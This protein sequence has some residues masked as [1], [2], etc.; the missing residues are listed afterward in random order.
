MGADVA[1]TVGDTGHRRI[2][3]PDGQLSGALAGDAQLIDEPLLDILRIDGGDLAD[4]A[5]GDHLAGHLHHGVAGIGIGDAENQVFLLGQGH[6]LLRLLHS[7]AQRLFA[8]HMDPVLQEA[9]GHGVVGVVRGGDADEID[10]VG[11]LALRLGHGLIAGVHAAHVQGVGLAGLTVLL[12][13]GGEAARHQLCAGVK[14]DGFAMHL[15]DKGVH[16][17]T[18]HAVTDLNTHIVLLVAFQLAIASSNFTSDFL[19]STF[20]TKAAASVAPSI[21]SIPLSSHSTDRGPS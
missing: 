3:A 21:R 17:A 14:G 15:A 16:V 19:K 18:D 13:I 10:T 20:F 7:E 6:Q 1:H 8:H 5:L 9:L 12:R 11:T 2:G 4:L